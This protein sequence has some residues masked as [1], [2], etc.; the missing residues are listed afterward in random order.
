MEEEHAAPPRPRAGGSSPPRCIRAR[1][2]TAPLNHALFELLG[3]PRDDLVERLLQR[4]RRL[5]AQQLLR[6][7]NGRDSPANVVPVGLV[8]D[9]PRRHIAADLPPDQLRELADAGR[10]GSGEVE[11]LVEGGRTGHAET[12]ASGQVP[13]IGEM[14][15]LVAISEDVERV[16]ALQDLE[17]EV[18]HDMAHR[19][20]YVAGKDLSRP[21]CPMLADAHA[22]EGPGDGVGKAVLL[23]S[24]LGEILERE[25]LEAVR[26]RR[27]RGAALLPFRGGKASGVLED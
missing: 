2:A 8:R 22:V 10:D 21:E 3:D 20:P 9:D 26:G 5:E 1:S 6:L 16:L 15:D 27:R 13:S 23:A 12:D 19:Q 25:L 4:S 7:P 14:T 11:V 18:R 17:D 24:P